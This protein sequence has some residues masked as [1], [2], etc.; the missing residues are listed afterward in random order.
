[1]VAE[2]NRRS[3]ARLFIDGAFV[4]A[5]SGET[6]PVVE[7]ATG[8]E[9]GRYAV[10][11]PADVERAVEAAHRAQPAWAATSYEERAGLLRRVERLIEERADEL[12]DIIVRETGS[13]RGKAGYEIHASQ[14]E[15]FEGAALASR[16][17]GEI[18]PSANTGKLSI[19]QRI[20]VGVVA[21]ITPWNFP[22]ILG[23]RAV[24]PA[25]A[26]GN[27]VVL[28][29][30]SLTPICGGQLLAELFEAAGAP[31]GILNVLTGAGDVVGEPLAAHPL[32]NMIHLTGSTEVGIRMG[33]IAGRG[34][35][36]VSLELGGN[37]ALVILD[38]ADVE[39]A[40]MIGA[41]SSWHYQGQTCI[42]ASRQIVMRAVA[43]EYVEALVRRARAIVV[44]DP[45]SD[46]VGLG[47]M[48]SEGQRD[49]AHGLVEASVAQGATV[50]EGGTYD[51][52]FYRPT[53]L[54]GVTPE[55]PAYLEEVFGPVAP[56]TVVD[57]EE[58]A[59][60]LVNAT[61]YG[62]VNA[63]FTADIARGLAFAEKVHSGM[64]HVNDATPLD[65]AHVPFGGLG[66]SG[67]GGRSGGDSNL[68]E[69]TERRWISIQRTPVHYP[70]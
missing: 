19:S 29:P 70:Y 26:L 49:H 33:E 11:T 22:F 16:P 44:G 18:L 5:S 59:L 1:M 56:I 9:M 10:A 35:K 39:T 8:M 40:S 4:D 37:N 32:V 43:D 51:G 54:T 38:D 50:A 65:E 64:V 36:K 57:T 21:V 6:A 52:L 55:M 47:P 69:F 68:E 46:K 58:E 2:V 12:A 66:M 41:W 13:I 28:K 20:P 25:L 42:T 61:P 14:N 34:L 53:V 45:A 17:T 63:V 27:T 48:I 67:M 7:K 62:L 3:D 24:A 60:D 30:A 31:A 23:F 15:L